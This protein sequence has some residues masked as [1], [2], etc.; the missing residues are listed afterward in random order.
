M[1]KRKGMTRGKFPDDERDLVLTKGRI[2]SM[3]PMFKP[4]TYWQWKMWN[5]DGTLHDNNPRKLAPDCTTAFWGGP[6]AKHIDAWDKKHGCG[7]YRV[8][9]P[10]T[11]HTDTTGGTNPRN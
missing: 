11:P 2:V 8:R 7:K 10:H 5:R 3:V 4:V 6:M 1:K 9:P